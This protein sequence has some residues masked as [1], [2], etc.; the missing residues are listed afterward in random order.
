MKNNLFLLHPL[1]QGG[2]RLR[3]E[4]FENALSK[5]VAYLLSLDEG[6]FL[7]G[8]YENAGIRTPYIRY[9]G[10]ENMLIGGH[11]AGHYLSALAQACVNPGVEETSRNKLFYKLRRMTDGLLECQRNSKGEKGFLWAAPAAGK[12]VEAQFDN[13]EAGKTDIMRE[14]WVPWYT[15]HKILA[16]LLDG[17]RLCGYAPSLEAAS[18]LGDW[19]AQRALRWDAA[20]QQRVL[21]VEYGGMNDCMYELYTFTGKAEHARA[22]HVFDEEALFD[23]ILSERKDVLNNRHANTTIPKIIG[24][25][26]RYIVLHG[27]VFDGGV[28]DASRYLRVAQAFFRMVV[29]R[30][31]YATGGNSEWEH[32][33]RDY[34]L[35]AERTNCN[36]E[37]CNVY[38]MLK[39]ARLLFCI[40]KDG[41]YADYYDNAFTNSILSSQNPET[42]MTTYFQ[43]MASGF[44]KVF[45]RPYDNFWCCTGSGMENF[46]KL[47]DS[48]CYEGE[49]GLWLEQY[50]P[51]RISTERFEIEI[52]CDFPFDDRVEISVV[53]ADAPVLLHLRIPDWAAGD[54]E[55][56]SLRDAR[57]E[58]GH[59]ICSG[60]AGERIAFRIPVTVTAAGLPD[61]RSVFAFR[62]GGAVLSADLGRD[63]M[64]ETTTGVDV[65]IPAAR[66][67]A[68]ERIYFKSVSDVL[69]DPS[70][71]LVRDGKIFRLMGGDIPLEYGLHYL[72]RRERYAIYMYLCEGERTEE[73]AGRAVL[74]SLQPGY[75]QYETDALH[76]LREEGS[77][78]CTADGTYRFARGGGWFEYD[79]RVDPS[80]DN[81]LLFYLRRD[82][83]GK[84]LTI[85]VGGETIFAERLQYTMGE[86]EYA[87][88]L[89]MPRALLARVCRKKHVGGEDTVVAAIRFS[90]EAE[91]DGARVCECVAVQADR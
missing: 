50:L 37:T 30:H 46:T 17:Y 77:C 16:G 64:A 62:Y 73:R 58:E 38:N 63:D 53:R 24:A 78:S 2:I 20:T 9:G 13:V 72:R 12:D 59:L 83:N 31:T 41:C 80:C 52:S 22:A 8:F 1:K 82:D 81:I 65:A 87:K 42:G 7:A 71:F 69:T 70:R 40:T 90:G 11:C 39:L 75:G 26:K 6:R 47:G 29:A 88:E 51:A 21:S 35:D 19:A 32:F 79:M 43:P 3:G 48:M 54:P 10:W 67:L 56:E 61:N 76:A 89:I 66:R 36:C 44:F 74:D 18:A 5:E 27:S 85:C 60:K 25:L 86:E 91:A 14:A 45:S 33:G 34:V 28:I 68:T 23:E 4:F 15:V 84:M 55:G 49:G 57:R